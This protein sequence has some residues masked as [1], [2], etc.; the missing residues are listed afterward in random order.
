MKGIYKI[1]I[2]ILFFSTIVAYGQQEPENAF[3]R[4]TMNTLNPAYAGEGTHFIFNL[5]SQWQGV[6]DAPQTQTFIGSTPIN[7]RIGLGISVVNDQTFIEKETAVF[8]DFS[9][10]LPISRSTNLF[11]GLK[12]GGN[13]FSVNT[14][15]LQAFNYT[16][17]PLLQD[18]SRFNPNIGIGALLKGEVFFVSLS[19]P[20]VLNTKR[21]EE[22]DA[23]VTQAVESIHVA[24]A[25]GYDFELS[26]EWVFKPSFLARVVEGGPVSLIGTAAV[27]YDER[28]EVGV[29]YRTDKAVTAMV[30]VGIIDW[31]DIGYAYDNSL[32]SGINEIGGG[33]HEIL[34]KVD[35]FPN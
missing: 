7:D 10:K 11:F 1:P 35:L 25:A 4:Y 21:F 2:I 24:F 26:Y 32:R 8:I 5:R 3:Y 19:S 17:D 9:Y 16:V 6:E 15:G 30:L 18:Q 34:L 23:T 14:S 33:T 22:N 20:G 27:A 28:F 31:L 12:G 13:F 29:S